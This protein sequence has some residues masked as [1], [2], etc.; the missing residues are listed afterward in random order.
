M[1]KFIGAF[2]DKP[3]PQNTK[4]IPMPSVEVKFVVFEVSSGRW[5]AQSRIFD[6]WEAAAESAS[7][8]TINTKGIYAWSGVELPNVHEAMKAIGKA[9]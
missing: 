7:N 2:T 3:L 5:R 8:Q 4:Q 1:I 9:K 6:T